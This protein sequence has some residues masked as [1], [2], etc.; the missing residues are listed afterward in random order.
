M[1]G[2]TV[3]VA[4][5]LAFN[6][7]PAPDADAAQLYEDC[8]AATFALSLEDLPAE[9]WTSQGFAY[10]C[11]VVLTVPVDSNEADSAIVNSGLA[12]E[13][14]EHDRRRTV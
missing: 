5:L 3:T 8:I 9:G 7:F 12:N 2:E 1:S 13:E 11:A 10:E 6:E 14:T 4:A